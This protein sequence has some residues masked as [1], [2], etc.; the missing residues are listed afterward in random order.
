[1][2]STS[3]GLLPRPWRAP[4]HE[5]FI[6]RDEEAEATFASP[7]RVRVWLH[8]FTSN[9]MQFVL[10]I[11]RHPRSWTVYGFSF[12]IAPHEHD[13]D[14]SMQLASASDMALLF[15][16]T[17]L[18]GLSV[19]DRSAD[20]PRIYLHGSN[21]ARPPDAS[22]YFLKNGT[23]DIRGYRTYVI[24]HEMGHALGLGHA[25][26]PGA[27]AASPVLV[28]QSKG[29]GA[30]VRDPWVVKSPARRKPKRNLKT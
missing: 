16:H 23:P 6:D 13:C 2:T 27:G 10:R 29:C 25:S 24:L 4:P 30:C 18:R 1:M 26:C 17:F 19:T 20:K 28:Q 8:N 9:E 11:L 21:W 12:E 14:V 5:L 3:L 7:R 22:G 15:P